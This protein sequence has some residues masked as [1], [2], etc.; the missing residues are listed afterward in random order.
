MSLVIPTISLY[1]NNPTT[2][3]PVSANVTSASTVYFVVGLFEAQSADAPA[4]AVPS[5][6][7]VAA[8]KAAAFTLPGVTLAIFPVGLIITG[9]WTVLFVGVFAMGTAGRIQARKQ[10][11]MNMKLAQYALR[12]RSTWH[13][14]TFGD[15]PRPNYY[16]E[17]VPRSRPMVMAKI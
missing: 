17:H 3:Q 13:H 10:Y 11:R 5:A 7:A 2:N 14:K 15:A 16:T 6:A 4:A 9:T 1:A 8:Q 12:D